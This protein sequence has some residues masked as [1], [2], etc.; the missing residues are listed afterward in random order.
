M[1]T[2]LMSL[3]INFVSSCFSRD[4]IVSMMLLLVKYTIRLHSHFNKKNIQFFL[5]SSASIYVRCWILS[6]FEA[7]VSKMWVGLKVLGFLLICKF[8]K[9]LIYHYKK[10]GN[11][12]QEKSPLKPI[13]VVGKGNSGNVSPVKSRRYCPKCRR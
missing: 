1:Y 6:R 9:E 8:S 4:I 13:K 3:C 2:Y 11:Q 5:A 10:K 12:Q 7:L